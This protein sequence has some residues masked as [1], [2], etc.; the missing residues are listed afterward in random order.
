MLFSLLVLLISG[1]T[2]TAVWQQ[3]KAGRLQ[4]EL[5]RALDELDQERSRSR[6]YEAEGV[7]RAAELER[8]RAAVRNYDYAWAIR[9]VQVRPVDDFS[10]DNGF[11]RLM[12]VSADAL[13]QELRARRRIKEEFNAVATKQNGSA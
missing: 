12:T 5:N 7:S 1:L 2:A 3:H 6:S 13:E 9:P 8:L 11:P 10:R 4:T